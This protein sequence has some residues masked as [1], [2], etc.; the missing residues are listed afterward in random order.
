MVRIGVPKEIHPGERRVAA[1]PETVLRLRKLGFEVAVQA[2][3]GDEISYSDS[4]YQEAGAT[5]VDSV[6]ELWASSDVVIKVRPPEQH[7]ALGVHEADLL[8]ENGWLI[9][10][11]WVT[12]NRE[13]LD[14]LAKRKATVF[15]MDC[16][17]RI[18]RAQKMDTLSAM[19]NIAGYR[20]VIEAANHF[21]RFFAGQ[22]TAAGRID[23]AKVLV[24]GA[25]VAGL[26][27]IGAARS[28]GAIVKAFDPRSACLDQVRSMGAEFLEI[29]VSEEGEGTG[30]YAK[31]MS[32]SFLKAE[33][34][35]F[36]AQ[37]MEV[38]III[39]TALIPGKPAPKL[40]TK[41]MVESMKPGSVIVDLAAEQ[42]GNC[43][44]TEPGKVVKYKGVTIVGYTDLPSR[45]ATLASQLYSSTIVALLEEL[46]KGEELHVDLEDPVV[47]GAL[48]LHQGKV[49]WPPPVLETPPAAPEP[50]V[51]THSTASKI[52]SSGTHGPVMKEMEKGDRSVMAGF[53]GRGALG[54][55]AG[56]TGFDARALHGLYA[57]VLCR[58][59][60]GVERKT[61]AAH[62]A[63]ECDQ[64]HQRHYPDRRHAAAFRNGI[65]AD[66]DTRRGRRVHRRHQRRR[67]IFSDKKNAGDVS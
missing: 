28:L 6:K 60:G 32:D 63:H 20:A 50:G 41:G 56:V 2:G 44:M 34:A 38:D 54:S 46:K 24:I 27:A 47:R 7:P 11:I 16:I 66:L 30:G 14:R 52:A 15:A 59:A 55:R 36:A 58:V 37:A 45:M 39:T 65:F 19:A 64:R 26:S 51:P 18:T 10:F 43:A 40:I 1:T 29:S 3:T 21:P 35:L 62:A 23:P 22:I 25:G 61:G 13:L 67:R 4:A 5:I 57:G 17:P 33:M 8:R 42:G 9:G 53:G 12:Q 48:V 49:T 31:E